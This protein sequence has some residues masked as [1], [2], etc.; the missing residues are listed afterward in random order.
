FKS[1]ASIDSR[2]VPYRSLRV[3]VR[4]LL[5]GRVSM[6]FLSTTY[7]QLV[8]EGKLRGFAVSSLKR[9]AAAPDLPTM[10][11]SGF[12]D[13]DATGWFALWLRLEPRLQS[14]TR[15][16]GMPSAS[17]RCPNCAKSKS[18]ARPQR[19]CCRQPGP[20]PSYSRW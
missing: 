18:E 2:R 7:L 20:C 1:M 13:F 12:P 3:A 16:S 15:F 19:H 11:E 6:A 5:A 17:Y 10:A 4:D 14:S 8:R 9:A